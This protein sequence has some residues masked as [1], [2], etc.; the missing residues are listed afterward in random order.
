MESYYLLSSLSLPFPSQVPIS[1]GYDYTMPPQQAALICNI[2]FNE[3]IQKG[4][5]A[6][7]K[8]IGF[9]IHTCQ[10]FRLK[11]NIPLFGRR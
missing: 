10:L 1:F 9:Q 11:R 7:H 8:I 2:T 4:L 5:L 3:A 6:I